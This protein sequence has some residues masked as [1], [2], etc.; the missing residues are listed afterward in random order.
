[1]FD[2]ALP[3]DARIALAF[4]ADAVEEYA[5]TGS[6][7]GGDL[8]FFVKVAGEGIRQAHV[9]EAQQAKLA[10]HAYLT[11]A[12]GALEIAYPND[13]S[14]I[15]EMLRVTVATLEQLGGEVV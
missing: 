14:V 10:A 4:L 15:E 13:R 7:A 1:M 12:Y 9:S 8:D 5:S 3:K 2:Q 6:D 11:A